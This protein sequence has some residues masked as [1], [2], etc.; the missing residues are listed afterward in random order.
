MPM[1]MRECPYCE[2]RVAPTPCNECPSCKKDMGD[3]VPFRMRP[4]D[5]GDPKEAPAYDSMAPLW[6]PIIVMVL[7]YLGAMTMAQ[8]IGIRQAVAA[9]FFGLGLLSAVLARIVLFLQIS[10]QSPVEAIMCLL[11]PFGWVYFAKAH[12]RRARWPVTCGLLG[13]AAMV[14]S[15]LFGAGEV[16]K[17]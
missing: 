8:V 5:T 1:E 3:P 10:D 17:N 12:W 9:A 11:A 2:N 13:V 7:V 4:V 15:V 14:A 16:L 6:K